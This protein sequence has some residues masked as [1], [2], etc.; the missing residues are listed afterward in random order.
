M[1]KFIIIS[2]LSFVLFVFISIVSEAATETVLFNTSFGFGSKNSTEVM[3]LQNFLSSQGFLKVAPTGNYFNLTKKAV[4]AFQVSQGIQSTGYL[5]P[6]TRA[7]IN[8]IIAMQTTSTKVIPATISIK[9]VS[10]FD[11]GLAASVVLSN[12]KIIRWQTSNYPEGVGVNINLLR[13]VSDTPD[14]YKLIRT[15]AKDTPNDG[16]E[17]WIPRSGEDGDDIYIE[18]TCSST[19]Q[20]NQGC[21]FFGTP[22]KVN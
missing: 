19:Y 21:T 7:S 11:N 16:Q 10:S 20:F 22:I 13:K 14:T 18:A 17:K 6:V 9:S 5:G 15:I 8:K 12:S 4:R 1:K 2:I 3:K